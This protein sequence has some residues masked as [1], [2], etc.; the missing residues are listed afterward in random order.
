MLF[1][2]TQTDQQVNDLQDDQA[3]HNGQRPSDDNAD[4]MKPGNIPA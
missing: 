4:E 1:R 3:P 2:Y